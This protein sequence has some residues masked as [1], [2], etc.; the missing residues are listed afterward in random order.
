[1]AIITFA[2]IVKMIFTTASKYN[3]VSNQV[4]ENVWNSLQRYNFTGEKFPV[5]YYSVVDGNKNDLL[6]FNRMYYNYMKQPVPNEVN[7]ASLERSL[8]DSMKAGFRF[9]AG[10]Y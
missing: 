9:E 7:K 3:T 5:H 8:C 10:F 4:I 2:L 6:G 1:M